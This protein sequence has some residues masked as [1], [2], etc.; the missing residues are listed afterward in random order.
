MQAPLFDSHCHLD[1]RRF[2][3]DHDAVL[4]RASEAGMAWMVTVGCAR[5]TDSID[6]AIRIA[7]R[8]P[9]WIRATVG[10]HPHDADRCDAQMLA[11]LE[12]WAPDPMVVAVGE[13]GLDF[14]YDHSARAAQYHAF[15]QQIALARKVRKPIVVHTRNAPDDTLQILREERAADVGGII[16]CFS[17]DAPFAKAALDLGFVVSFS[18]LVTFPKGTEGIRDAARALPGDA[19]LVETDAPYLAPVPYRGKRNEPSYV[20]YTAECIAELRGEDPAA[21]RERTT[22]NA[23]RLF[24]LPLSR[25]GG[26]EA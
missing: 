9:D 14:H 15:R 4:T 22:A 12:D 1:D 8:H 26:N 2:R 16:H 6:A 7:R 5:S 18:G 20:A 23:C 21:V 11:A 17:E 19:I 25:P 13:M 10:V 24:G 3:D